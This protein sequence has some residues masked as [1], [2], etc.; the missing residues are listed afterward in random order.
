MSNRINTISFNIDIAPKAH[1]MGR[2]LLRGA[3]L[4]SLDSIT[5]GGITLYRINSMSASLV[6]IVGGVDGN[7]GV[8]VKTNAGETN[9]YRGVFFIAAVNKG[10]QYTLSAW[11][12]GTAG[13]TLCMEF[14]NSN[15]TGRKNSDG[16]SGTYQSVVF[17][18]TDGWQRVSHTFTVD[19]KNAGYVECNFFTNVVGEFTISEPKLERGDTATAFC[20]NEDDLKG[21]KG[22]DAISYSI[23][24]DPNFNSSATLTNSGSTITVLVAGKFNLYSLTGTKKSLYSG[25]AYYALSCAGAISEGEVTG[26]IGTPN[27]SKDF[28][29]KN[30][31]AIPS[32][33]V[34]TVYKDS[35]KTSALAVQIIPISINAGAIAEFDQQLGQYSIMV[36]SQRT[37]QNMW[38]NGDFSLPDTL[39]PAF[40]HIIGPNANTSHVERIDGVDLP[41]GFLHRLVFNVPVANGGIC[42]K[43]TQPHISTS[44]IAETGTNGLV[45]KN[46]YVLSLYAKATA[47]CDMAIGLEN[48]LTKTVNLTGQWQRFS[49]HIPK[50]TDLSKWTTA[51]IFYP[52]TAIG[53]DKYVCITGIQFETGSTPQTWSKSEFDMEIAGLRIGNGGIEAIAGKFDYIGKDGK[54]YIRVEQDEN[55]YPHFV[56]YIPGTEY[57]AYDLGSTGLS[58]IVESSTKLTFPLVKLSGEVKDMQGNEVSG[59]FYIGKIKWK[60]TDTDYSEVDVWNLSY[61]YYKTIFLGM[62]EFHPAHFKNKAGTTIYVPTNAKNYE[63]HLYWSQNISDGLPIGTTVEDG[64]YLLVYSVYS[65]TKRRVVGYTSDG[66]A[67]V[68]YGDYPYNEVRYL[69]IGISGGK[70]LSSNIGL[71]VQT[72][73][74]SGS[75]MDWP[76]KDTSKGVGL[77]FVFLDDS[78]DSSMISYDS[79]NGVLKFYQPVIK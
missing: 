57:P 17:N 56:F 49:V 66:M 26:G 61:D 63:N 18:L 28:D 15:G 47:S 42:Y 41:D 2:N 37:G 39:A 21:D 9:V 33:A 27:Y 5:D 11:V 50:G 29:S 24:L 10:E 54:P 46:D 23:E 45:T 16:T 38:V 44:T 12:K 51:V 62:Y 13:N 20:L 6:K 72:G 53:T 31:S 19:S 30:Q 78:E 71:C 77:S 35:T 8:W 40:S 79:A 25:T 74:L 36:A 70:I 67:I 64:W 60:E 14:V 4:T 3:G 22:T 52:T 59:N 55:G 75:I 32:S 48:V 76:I 69:A 58:Q 1:D 73:P 34:L 68:N 43:G 65:H 7:K